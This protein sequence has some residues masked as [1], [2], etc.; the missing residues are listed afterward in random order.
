[1]PTAVEMNSFHQGVGGNQPMPVGFR[2]QHRAIVSDAARSLTGGG[3]LSQAGDEFPFT[4]HI[5]NLE[6]IIFFTSCLSGWPIIHSKKGQDF[7]GGEI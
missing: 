7:S 6:T 1:M 5:L 3:I 4:Q 2:R